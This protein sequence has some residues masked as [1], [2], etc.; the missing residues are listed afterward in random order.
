MILCFKVGETWEILNIFCAG[1]GLSLNVSNTSLIDVEEMVQPLGCKVEEL[2][3]NY[4]GFLL[5]GNQC[6]MAF[7]E[8]LIDKFKTKLVKWRGLLFSKGG[9]LILAQS[10]LNGMM[11]YLFSLIRAPSK[12]ISSMEKLMTDFIRNWGVYKLGSHLGWSWASLPTQHMGS[13]VWFLEERNEALLLKEMTLE[14]HPRRQEFVE[15][16]HS[17]YLWV[18]DSWMVELTG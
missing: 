18:G 2:P 9:R 8:P 11:R 17:N 14:I 16:C 7:L 3:I 4:L 12:V 1:S 15:M 13:G 6:S 5:G 10:I